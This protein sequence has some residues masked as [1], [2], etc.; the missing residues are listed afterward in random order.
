MKIK[1]RDPDF[2]NTLIFA[3]ILL[4]ALETFFLVRNRLPKALVQ[5]RPVT[6][7]RPLEA[8]KK[9]I[10]PKIAIIIDDWG[11][12]AQHCQILKE[13]GYPLTIS[14]L[15]NLPHSDTIAQ[16]AHDSHK[17]VILHLPLEPYESHEEYPKNYV[18]NTDMSQEEIQNILGDALKSVSFAV[19]I[20]NHMGSKATEDPALMK[21]IFADLK[22]KNLYFVDSLVTSQSVGQ[23]TSRV[24]DLPFVSRDVF[25]DNENDQDYITNQLAQLTRIAQKRGYAIGIGHD[26][27]LTLN[28]LKEQM[29]LLTREG[30]EFVTVTQLLKTKASYEHSRN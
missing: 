30:F 26:R 14:I 11:Y 22:K 24:F 21:T 4:V 5:K 2:K 27:R 9:T 18:I 19:G 3:L 7:E 25:L 12:N 20:S 10:H 8:R 1:K 23:S 16:C 17:D 29:E 28:V 13:I 15:P 6:I